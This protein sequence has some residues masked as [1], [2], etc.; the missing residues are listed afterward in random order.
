MRL[1]LSTWSAALRQH[2]EGNPRGEVAAS[3]YLSTDFFFENYTEI[4][5]DLPHPLVSGVF[6]EYLSSF[7][8]D[9]VFSGNR[10]SGQAPLLTEPSIHIPSKP[11]GYLAPEAE[12]SVRMSN[13]PVLEAVF[14]QVSPSL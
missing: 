7:T 13:R 1:T 14:L 2:G 5:H 3:S 4:P 6:S 11:L 10:R 8:R 12:T 9:G